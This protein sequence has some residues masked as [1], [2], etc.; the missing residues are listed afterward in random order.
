M[1][2]WQLALM[3]WLVGAPVSILTV[4][5]LAPRYF[6]WRNARILALLDTSLPAPTRHAVP[7][8]S[9]RAPGAC[10]ERWHGGRASLHAL[11]GSR[12]RRG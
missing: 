7:G 8:R 4:A 12:T 2:G 11:S 1:S 5:T 10:S 9:A 3:T 6:S